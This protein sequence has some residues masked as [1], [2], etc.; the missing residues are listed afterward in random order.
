MRTLEHW[1]ELVAACTRSG[2]PLW[3][4][5]AILEKESRGR[6]VYG[7]DRGGVFSD[8]G[9]LEVTE[10]NFSE[11]LKRVQAGATSNGVGPMQITYPGHFRI[12]LGRGLRPW[13][14]ADNIDYG[15]S[16]IAADTKRYGFEQAATRYNLGHWDRSWPYGKDAVAKAAKW[17][18]QLEGQ[19]TVAT[20]T[21][22]GT[23]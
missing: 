13:I 14:P 20:Q 11:F 22:D 19:E 5:A 2:L 4:G 3:Q 12:M 18:Q 7:H 15:I 10:K 1:S 16:L 9:E 8:A 17:K 23:T 6:A 21:I